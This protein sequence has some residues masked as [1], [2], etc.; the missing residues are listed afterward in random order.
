M[1]EKGILK[2]RGSESK[3]AMHY[4]K[5]QD[6][7]VSITQKTSRKVKHIKKN[8]SIEIALSLLSRDFRIVEIT[9]IEDEKHVK[10]VYDFML[11][12]KHTHY[13]KSNEGLV[14]L[15]YSNLR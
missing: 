12:Q 11:N 4:I 8:N 3:G 7:Y 10:T 13:K 2:F 5:Y 1:K 14:V 15:S 6:G 9:I